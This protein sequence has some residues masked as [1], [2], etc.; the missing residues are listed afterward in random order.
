MIVSSAD[1]WAMGLSRCWD[2]L[3]YEKAESL[4]QAR[5]TMRATLTLATLKP[6]MLAM[7]GSSKLALM[8]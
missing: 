4:F 2:Q 7:L 6:M 5:S 3:H 1:R 8:N